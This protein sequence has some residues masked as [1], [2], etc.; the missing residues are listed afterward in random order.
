MTLKF[1]TPN[2][3]MKTVE[4]IGNHP[5]ITSDEVIE[6]LKKENFKQRF[7]GQKFIVD[8]QQY[9]KMNSIHYLTVTDSIVGMYIERHSFDMDSDEYQLTTVIESE[10]VEV[11]LNDCIRKMEEAKEMVAHIQKQFTE[12]QQQ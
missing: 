1:L 12:M 2:R 3:I 8:P 11:V 5:V 4:K 7:A 6:L 9:L 10:N